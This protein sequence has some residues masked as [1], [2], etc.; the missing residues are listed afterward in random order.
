MEFLS[1]L[2]KQWKYTFFGQISPNNVLY[3]CFDGIYKLSTQKKK[4]KKI[5][6]LTGTIALILWKESLNSDGQ[7]FH[8]YQQNEHTHLTSTHWT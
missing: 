3:S 8:Q 1:V 5:T 2:K 4:L 6:K 7:Q